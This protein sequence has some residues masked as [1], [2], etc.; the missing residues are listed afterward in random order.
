MSHATPALLCAH[1]MRARTVRGL[2]LALLVSLATCGAAAGAADPLPSWNDG[3]AKSAIVKLVSG[4][5]GVTAS[6]ERVAKHGTV[7]DVKQDWKRVFA[8]D[9]R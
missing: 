4:A 6:A 2:W 8:F 3:A 7:V 5:P 9:A 1:V